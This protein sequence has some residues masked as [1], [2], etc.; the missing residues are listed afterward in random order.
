MKKLRCSVRGQITHK[1]FMRRTGDWKA[2]VSASVV[3]HREWVENDA[4]S[5]TSHFYFILTVHAQD[6]T[7]TLCVVDFA[8][9]DLI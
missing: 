6:T 4:F 1:G 2:E 9:L 5:L 8:M 7:C 3:R